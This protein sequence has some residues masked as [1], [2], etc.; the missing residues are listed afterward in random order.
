M[1]TR[2]EFTKYNSLKRKL[3]TEINEARADLNFQRLFKLRDLRRRCF[4][5]KEEVIGQVQTFFNAEEAE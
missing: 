5:T 2:S 3:E 4:P 1:T